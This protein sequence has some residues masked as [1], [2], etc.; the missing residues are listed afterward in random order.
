PDTRGFQGADL[1]NA[2]ACRA[3]VPRR[4]RCP[5]RSLPADARPPARSDSPR[6]RAPGRHVA[7]FLELFFESAEE[8]RI[9]DVDT[10]YVRRH[11]GLQLREIE[12]PAFPVVVH[13]AHLEARA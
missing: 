8:V 12:H 4:R 3:A 10:A 11:C 7:N 13:L 9:L 6:R 2:C 1:Q 5:L